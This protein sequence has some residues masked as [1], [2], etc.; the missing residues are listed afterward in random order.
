MQ[1][2]LTIGEIQTTPKTATLQHIQAFESA[3]KDFPQVDCPVDHAFADGLYRRTV[4]MPAG[5]V[6]TSKYHKTN[7]FAFIMRGVVD[8]WEPNGPKIRHVAPCMF[9]TPAGT[10]RVLHVIEETEWATVHAT[11][12]KDVSLIERDIIDPEM[13]L[14]GGN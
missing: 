1:Y 5:L 8:V 2:Q 4:T 14:I 11:E 6:V 13:S 7:H 9:I 10:K 12:H 3:I